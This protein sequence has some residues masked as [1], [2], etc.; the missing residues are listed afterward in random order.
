M[1]V[2][3]NGKVINTDTIEWIDYSNF[4]KLGYVRVHCKDAAVEIVQGNEALVVLSELCPDALEG[5]QAEYIRHAWAIHNLLGH[6]L[7]QILSWLGL[8]RLGIKIHDITTP[9]PITKE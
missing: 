2:H 1:F 3:Y 9:F 8:P 4:V 7:M 6:P 5:H